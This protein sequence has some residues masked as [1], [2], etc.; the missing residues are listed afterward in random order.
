MGTENRGDKLVGR[1][2]NMLKGIKKHKIE[3][4]IRESYKQKRP[5][6]VL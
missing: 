2:R 4:K 1:R 6:K 5:L 3:K